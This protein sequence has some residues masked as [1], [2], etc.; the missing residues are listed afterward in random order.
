MAQLSAAAN[1]RRSFLRFVSL[2]AAGFILLCVMWG[3][4]FV[5]VALAIQ[6]NPPVLFTA[7][8][9]DLSAVLFFLVVAIRRP[10]AWRPVGWLHW[11]HVAVAAI[12][13][14]A[15]HNA[16]FAWGQRFT[17]VSVASVLV[18]LSP[19]LTAVL[20]RAV[21]RG[22]ELNARALAGLAMGLVGVALVAGLGPGSLR[23][24]RA[25]GEFAILVAVVLFAAGTVLVEVPPARL[26]VFAEA[27]WQSLIAAVLLHLL[28]PVLEGKQTFSLNATS[29]LAL[30][31]LSVVATGFG[32][33]LFL[34]LARKWGPTR[35]NLFAY[36]SPVVATL[37]G[38]FALGQRFE[39]RPLAGL[40]L[41]AA[42]FWLASWPVASRMPRAS[43]HALAIDDSGIRLRAPRRT[44]PDANDVLADEHSG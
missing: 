23:D 24:S 40:P 20:R 31:Y 33:V 9:F 21:G 7:V 2:D 15:L 18:G 38:Y 11:T 4:A 41:V 27:A 1:R 44:R 43:G 6:S 16:V 39:L 8:R 35:V 36:V 5:F 26:D 42:A 17:T 37:A 34:W 28:S 10:R 30:L 3:S 25:L 32:I 14:G 29:F 19:I 22:E 13:L 12:L